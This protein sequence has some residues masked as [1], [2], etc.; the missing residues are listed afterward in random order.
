[1]GTLSAILTQFIIFVINSILYIFQMKILQDNWKCSI[2]NCQR[3][4]KASG[5]HAN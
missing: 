2:S 5:C 4:H 1:M 3:I